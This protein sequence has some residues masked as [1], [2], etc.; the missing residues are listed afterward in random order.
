VRRARAAGLGGALL[1]AL[2][3]AGR[4]LAA[5]ATP[6]PSPA[7]G[8]L[9]VMLSLAFILA[10]I[11]A[12]AWLAKRLRLTPRTGTGAVRVLAD[13]P[14]GPKERVLLLQVGDAQALVGVG[15]D[16]VRSLRLL[17]RAVDVPAVEAAPGAFAERLRQLTRPAGEA[18]R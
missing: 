15:G 9:Q 10:F 13:V 11:L 17:E 7:A 14:V 1:A 8:L 2:A 18:P 12:L 3:P 5:A 6:V 16:G 4:A